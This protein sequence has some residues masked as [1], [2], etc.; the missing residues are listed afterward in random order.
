VLLL[1]IVL[2]ARSRRACAR[3]TGAFVKEADRE[4]HL[5]ESLRGAATLK[6]IGADH[7]TRWQYENHFAA[8][9]NM[10]S[11]KLLSQFWNWWLTH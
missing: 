8:V 4:N 1:N 2:V 11:R 7:L 9:A 6:M 10:G 5:I 3:S